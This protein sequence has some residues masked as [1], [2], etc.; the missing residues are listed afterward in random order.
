MTN[1]LPDTYQCAEDAYKFTGKERDPESGLDYFVARYYS[2]GLGRFLQG[3]PIALG[4]PH[5]FVVIDPQ[6]WNSYA[7]SVNRPLIFIDP[8]GRF[9]G[10]VHSRITENAGTKKEYS[11]ATVK[12]LVQANLRGTVQATFSTTRNMGFQ[13]W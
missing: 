3:D 9:S 6:R 12:L 7:Y 8:D 4:H 2:S 1:S 11:K 5:A 10:S 13:E